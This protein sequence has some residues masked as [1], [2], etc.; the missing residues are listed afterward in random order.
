[1]KSYAPSSFTAYYLEDVICLDS[2][3]G[4]FHEHY[5]NSNYKIQKGLHGTRADTAK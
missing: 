1:M 2:H 3:L 5:T 4:N